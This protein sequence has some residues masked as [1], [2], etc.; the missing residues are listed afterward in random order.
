[1]KMTP[2]SST[3]VSA[4][5][6]DEDNGWLDLA[7]VKGI[8]YR[9]RGVPPATYRRLLAAPSK[10]AFINAAIKGRYRYSVVKE[11]GE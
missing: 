3:T 5:G 7:Y 11:S 2:V 8:T 4:V 10:G 1:M 9:Y 6:Y